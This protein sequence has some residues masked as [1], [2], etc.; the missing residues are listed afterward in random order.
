[1]F[2][3]S[4]KNLRNLP[5]LLLNMPA[6]KNALLRYKT[7]DK[8][9]RNRARRW[10]LENLVEACSDALYEYSGKDE[11]LSVRTIQLD[12]QR[13]RSDELGYNAPIVVRDRKY[14][15]Y[16]DP[17]YSISN[18]PLTDSDLGQMRE[19]VAVLKQLS[20]FG[21]FSG[22]D[23]IVGRL[24]DYVNAVREERRPAIFLES[25]ERLKGLDLISPL[26]EAIVARRPV[27]LTYHSFKS[28]RA[29]SFIFSPYILKEYRNRWFVFGRGERDNYVVNLAL[30]RIEAIEAAPAEAR[31]IPDEKFVPEE[32]FRNMIGVTK[33]PGKGDRETLVRFKATPKF[34][35][36][37][38]TKPLHS[39]QMVVERDEDGSV[40]FQ[41][42]VC[43][44]FEL[45]KS[46]LE[47]ADG[48][49]VLRPKSLVRSIAAR[50]RLA[51]GQY[52]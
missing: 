41:L 27:L 46:L 11:Y 6:N 8:C 22:V 25:N 14:Y 21:G 9:L 12:I 26:Y 35:P 15:T 13:M 5:K 40:T 52:E 44:N 20:G 10:T 17:E 28:P 32:Y 2:L 30:D 49:K 38:E 42:D 33:I 31:F 19:A 37:I 16:E 3:R 50:L 34:A 4:E 48:V 1:M 29:K 7:I 36:Y 47:F 18:V 39:S 45:E 23:D 43:L 24:E 51:A